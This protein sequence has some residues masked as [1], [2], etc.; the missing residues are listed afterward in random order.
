VV[1]V[2]HVDPLKVPDEQT[3]GGD[4]VAGYVLSV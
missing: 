3:Y 1:V 2:V 4:I